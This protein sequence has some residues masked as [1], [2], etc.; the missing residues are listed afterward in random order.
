MGGTSCRSGSHDLHPVGV[1][2]E[3]LSMYTVSVAMKE[4]QLQCLNMSE[5][6]K[7]GATDSLVVLNI[8]T[9]QVDGP[10]G[11]KSCS[12]GASLSRKFSALFLVCL[13]ISGGYKSVM[14][15]Q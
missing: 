8:S 11:T 10:T 12:D 2:T 7:F 5:V 4:Q 3:S 6:E 13:S 14:S 9:A 15:F 1:L